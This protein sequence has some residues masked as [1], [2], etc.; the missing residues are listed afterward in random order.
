MF[1]TT[2][3]QSNRYIPSAMTL[4]FV[5]VFLMGLI[6]FIWSG[7]CV[8][9]RMFDSRTFCPIRSSKNVHHCLTVCHNR[10]IKIR[11]IIWT[12]L[13]L[14]KFLLA[15]LFFHTL[16][17]HTEVYL[18]HCIQEAHSARIFF[19]TCNKQSASIAPRAKTV[20]CTPFHSQN[21]TGEKYR[22]HLKIIRCQ[23][24]LGQRRQ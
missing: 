3:Y 1:M 17:I 23:I 5:L 16:V 21:K 20:H 18:N 9:L 15:V 13:N 7:Q 10:Y 19:Y 8:L 4:S 24:I 14:L 6:H 12:F 22:V 11:S 2:W